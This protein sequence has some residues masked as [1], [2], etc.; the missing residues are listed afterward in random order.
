MEL[1]RTSHAVYD[2]KYHLVWNPKYRK[3]MLRGV[4]QIRVKGTFEEIAETHDSDIGYSG[5]S[6]G[7]CSYISEFSNEV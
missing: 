5:G 7:S 6:R 3:W 1:K 2:T 4:I